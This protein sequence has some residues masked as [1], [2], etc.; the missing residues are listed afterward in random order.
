MTRFKRGDLADL[1][2][3]AFKAT[4]AAINGST[5]RVASGPLMSPRADAAGGLRHRR[6]RTHRFGGLASRTTAPSVSLRTRMANFS[7]AADSPVLSDV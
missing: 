3:L 1:E 6:P 7:V 5:T 4:A 2:L